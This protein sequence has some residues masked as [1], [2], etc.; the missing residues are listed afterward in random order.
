MHDC[1]LLRIVYRSAECCS[2]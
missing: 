1:L 2:L